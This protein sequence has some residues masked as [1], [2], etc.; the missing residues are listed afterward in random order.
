MALWVPH[1][2]QH[3]ASAACDV[4]T[5]KRKKTEQRGVGRRREDEEGRDIPGSGLWE[6][7]M[8]TS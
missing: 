6:R 4:T 2:C 1:P 8:K 5:A 3:D 7:R